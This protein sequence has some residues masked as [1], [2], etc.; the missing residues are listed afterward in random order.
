MTMPDT[1]PLGFVQQARRLLEESF[2]PC[3]G[4]IRVTIRC[5]EGDTRLTY[6]LPDPAV[7]DTIPD[8]ALSPLESAI[9]SII[10]D[11]ALPGKAIA[12]RIHRPY[13]SG[14]RVI[15]ANLCERR[16][17]VIASGHEGYRRVA[18]EPSCVQPRPAIVGYHEPNTNGCTSE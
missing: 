12:S 7:C 13:D 1:T 4:S 15:L 18:K 3:R 8:T 10:G 11:G 9:L 17:P 2:G 5:L 16:P 6:T 14:L